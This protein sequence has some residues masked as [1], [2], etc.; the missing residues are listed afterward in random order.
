[1][2]HPQTA[3]FLA[4]LLYIALPL[5]AWS[6]LRR[7]HNGRAVTLW[8]LG[9]GVFGIGTALI[10]MR[11]TAPAWLSFA[12]ANLMVFGS[13]ALRSASLRRELGQSD[14][15]RVSGAA[16]LSVSVLYLML[17]TISPLDAPRVVLSSA[18][19]MGG[20][21]SL[22]WL[23]WKL[24]RIK[25]YR[26]AAMLSVAYG[27]FAMSMLMRG[28][29]NVVNWQKVVVFSSGPEFVFAFIAALIAALYGNLGY[30]GI[31][32]ESA[33]EV[34]LARATE[35]SREQEKREQIELHSRELSVLLDERTQLLAHR[36]E[37][38]GVMAHEVRQ[39]LNNASAALQSAAAVLAR[40]H[41]GQE[42][43]LRLNRANAVLMQVSASIDNVLADAVLLDGGEAMV[44]QETDI[45]TLLALVLADI[46]PEVR[47]RVHV[48]RPAAART[49][50]MNAS[51]MRLALRNLI[52]NALVYSPADADVIVRVSDSD[53]PLGLNIDV[54]DR[55]PGFEP[56]V[57]DKLFT[58]GT[59]GTR[60][61][62]PGG[63]GLGLHIVQRV[64]HMHGGSAQL[65]QNLPGEAVVMRLV[66]PQ[67]EA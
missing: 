12:V 32:L 19:N 64:M 24:F 26:S 36:E 8:C 54:C 33:R 15:L 57:L 37:M 27:L 13:Y 18:A 5:T 22:S 1:M 44:R 65:V 42:A 67:T 45:D 14:G 50:D 41:D 16:W 3:F 28:V 48:E 20:A 29:V 55:G 66:L 21:L 34:E 63:H 43:M 25:G 47:H 4:G 61:A 17:L 53:N 46:S 7:R 59:R 30:I 11:G 10:G 62:Q 31:A 2:L 9:G 49:A 52:V 56:T 58:R 35:L 60:A 38:L 39:P 40:V 6:I 23:A 51:L